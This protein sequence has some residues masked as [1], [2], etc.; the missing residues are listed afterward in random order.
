[1]AYETVKRNRYHVPEPLQTGNHTSKNHYEDL[2]DFH[3]PLERMHNSNLHDYGIARGLGVN[4]TIGGTEIIVNPGVAIDSSG[5]LISLSNSG[6]GDIGKSPPAGE[7]HEVPVPVHLSTVDYAGQTVYVTIQFSEILRI[8]EGVLGRLEQVP[9]VRLQPVDTL[10]TLDEKS[11][12]EGKTIILAIAVIDTAGKLAELKVADSKHRR[13]LIGECIEELQIQ[14][15]SDAENKIENKLSGK[16]GPGEKGGLKVTVPD[17]HDN[18]L[19]AREDS[20]NFGN[21]ANLEIRANVG[22]GTSSPSEKLEVNGTVKAGKFVGD[23][24]GLIKAGQWTDIAGGISYD[25]GNVGIG[26]TNPVPNAKLDIQSGGLNIGGTGNLDAAI[27][28]KSS[29]GGFDRLLQMSPT[30]APKPGLNL[31]A[32]TNSQSQHQ[33]WVWGVDTDNKWKIQ[34]GINFSG[35]AGLSIDSFGTIRLY[36]KNA[37]QGHDS[38]LRINQDNEFPSGTHF[39]RR[40]NFA[41]GITTGNWWNVEPGGGSLLVQG[42]VGIGTTT[43]RTPLHVLGR[44]STGADFTSAGAITFFPPDGFAWFH[45]DNGPAGGRQMGRLRISHG[46]QPGT[47]ELMSILQ[48][49]N[50]GIGTP[51][52]GAKLDVAGVVRATNFINPSDAKFKTDIIPLT[53]VLDKLEKIRGVSFRWNELDPY[54][55]S[56]NG[57]EIGLIA[58]EVE[59]VFPELITM[60]GDES[61]LGIDYNRFTGVL[62]EAIKELKAENDMFKEKIKALE[63]TLLE[64]GNA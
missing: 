38:F 41:G 36:G 3:I 37:F 6:K 26:T 1:M 62:L 10:D 42:N 11:I 55:R 51:N 32:S 15:S 45:I 52:P 16:I 49:G 7:S 40:A 59:E 30:G 18:I 54:D 60:W 4:G 63:D 5:Q 58:Q 21:F 46:N 64:S 39:A 19:F 24:S 8:N 61:Y 34:P 57:R 25:A 48:S 29:Y 17:T 22:I 44:I 50:I 53:D 33:W 12:V 20:G 43:P 56:E 28:V 31:L 27:H 23:G 9:W 47:I 14:W 13:R 35:A 2:H